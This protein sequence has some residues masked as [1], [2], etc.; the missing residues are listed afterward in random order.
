LP[1]E[2]FPMLA[3]FLEENTFDKKAAMREFYLK[4]SR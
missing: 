4:S 1:E 2:Q 3:Q